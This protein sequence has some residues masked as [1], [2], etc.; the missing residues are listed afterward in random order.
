MFVRLTNS[1]EVKATDS[2]DK[3]VFECKISPA[4][5]IIVSS[6]LY[7]FNCS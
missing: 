1:S 3:S 5:T 7:T 4:K 2:G 6:G